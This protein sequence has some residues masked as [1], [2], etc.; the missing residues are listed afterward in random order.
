M[1]A[2]LR[3]LFVPFGTARVAATRY[4][5]CQYIPYLK[6]HNFQ[7]RVFSI[8]SEATTARMIA[9]PS[10]SGAAKLLYY[11]RVVV[12]KLIRFSAV[13]LLARHYQVV[14]LQRTTLPFALE[15]ALWLVNSNII[16]DIDDA[17]FMPDHQ[18][19]GLIGRIKARTKAME[20]S[21]MLKLSKFVIVENEYIR[22]YCAK[23]CRN[24][25]LIPGPIDTERN[26]P[27]LRRA[28]ERVVIGWIGGPSTS[29]YLHML[30]G[31]LPV[32]ARKFNILVKLVGAGA[33]RF[34]GVETVNLEWSYDDEV[35]E[36]QSFDIGVMPMP[37]NEWTRGKLGCKMLQYM[38]VGVPAVVSYTPTNAEVVRNGEN[39]FLA[40]T[41]QEWLQ[42]I[43]CLINDEG[44][45]RRIGGQGRKTAE[46]AFSLR[47]NAPRL[48]EALMQVCR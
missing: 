21:G 13:L 44:L 15:K 18:E 36:L 22:S 17:I 45:R 48:T 37:D 30:D 14:F 24:I 34:P 27:R 47:V 46:E 40:K 1:P 16:F 26:F 23:Y 43:S 2:Q 6:E 19:E 39:G 7:C 12:E 38:A 28:S 41:E 9:S 4:R 25:L 20:V 29:V 5:V 42:A 3:V 33:Y 35:K 11:V 32:L 8:I 10:L 31:V